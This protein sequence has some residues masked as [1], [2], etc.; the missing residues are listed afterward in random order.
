[1]H[2]PI[3]LGPPLTGIVAPLNVTCNLYYLVAA[4]CLLT[5]RPDWDACVSSLTDM[6]ADVV[7]TEE[8]LK[9]DLG[10]SKAA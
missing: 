2:S 4:V 1:M 8:K 9:Q 6:G 10:R 7:T 3:W 5:L